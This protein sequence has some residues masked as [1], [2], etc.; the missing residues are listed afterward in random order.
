MS[1]HRRVEIGHVVI[2]IESDGERIRVYQDIDGS[3][4]VGPIASAVETS[5][6]LDRSQPR[7]IPHAPKG[8]EVKK[9]RGGR[10]T[11]VVEHEI[12]SL[13]GSDMRIKDIARKQ[14]VS[15][16]TVANVLKRN[17]VELRPR[18]RKPEKEIEPSN[19]SEAIDAMR[20]PRITPDKLNRIK[21]LLKGNSMSNR[22]IADEVGMEAEQI[23]RIRTS[24]GL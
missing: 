1:V 4:S 5:G 8:N 9:S 17:G 12:C 23:D 10:L 7:A 14:K 18:G 16:T 21:D 24:L 20:F 19:A 15:S 6:K 13:Y 11:E 3:S 2:F 22:E